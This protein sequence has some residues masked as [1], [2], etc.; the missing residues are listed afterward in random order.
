MD[1]IYS[2]LIS[3]NNTNEHYKGENEELN[4]KF[5]VELSSFTDFILEDESQKENVNSKISQQIIS[6]ISDGDGIITIEILFTLNIIKVKYSHKMLHPRPQHTKT[7]QEIQHFIQHNINCSASE[8]WYQIR[9]N[10]IKEHEYITVQQVQRRNY[11]LISTYEGELVNIF[12][13]RGSLTHKV[14]NIQ[15]IQDSI[16]DNED[17]YIIE[18][19][20]EKQD[21]FETDLAYLLGI[22]DKTKELLEESRNKTKG[23]LWLE[24]IR[25]NFKPLEKMNDDIMKL[26]NRRTM[27]QTWKDFNNNTQYW[28]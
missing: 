10:Q 5:N 14:S 7:T 2:S 3:L 27:P 9:E 17:C 23:H 4:M 8:I 6:Y 18:S 1:T 22:L 16:I 19:D 12:Q 13:F 24:R 11:P 21:T 20:D 25:S 15:V 26:K 28:E